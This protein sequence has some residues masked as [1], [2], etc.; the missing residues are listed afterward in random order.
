[1]AQTIINNA[2]DSSGQEN[3]KQ[4]VFNLLNTIHNRLVD[5]ATGLNGDINS[6]NTALNLSNFPQNAK[7]EVLAY[8]QAII[9]LKNLITRLHS[10]S[11]G[12]KGHFEPGNIDI[13]GVKTA[14]DACLPDA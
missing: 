1:M 10:T 3:Q 8:G 9:A 4:I 2:Y 12:H 14:L 13:N 5:L 11:N 6:A 7:D